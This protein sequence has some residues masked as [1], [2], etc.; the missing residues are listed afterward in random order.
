MKNVCFAVNFDCQLEIR[1]VSTCSDNNWNKNLNT[2]NIF[3][4]K[5]FVGAVTFF[6]FSEIKMTARV[7]CRNV[8]FVYLNL[9]CA[10]I[11][12]DIRRESHTVYLIWHDLF[13]GALL[14][15][16]ARACHSWLRSIA[17]SMHWS[18]SLGR[19]RARATID[20]CSSQSTNI[21]HITIRR[22]LCIKLDERSITQKR[23]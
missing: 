21:M 11:D 12:R 10:H 2:R 1:G 6:M 13:V 18:I 14:I 5:I 8:T 17:I 7:V 23:M 20:I 16:C 22:L 9:D 4:E 3:T 19:A 15:R